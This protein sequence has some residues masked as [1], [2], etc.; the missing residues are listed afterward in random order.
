MEKLTEKQ[1]KWLSKFYKI[2]CR[3][4]ARPDRNAPKG[5]SNADRTVFDSIGNK[6]F[7]RGIEQRIAQEFGFEIKQNVDKDI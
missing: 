5:G 3:G 4:S 7:A 1:L 2:A 6:P